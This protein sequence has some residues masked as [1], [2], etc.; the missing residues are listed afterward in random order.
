MT[1]TIGVYFLLDETGSMAGQKAEVV[2]GFN[3][4]LRECSEDEAHRYLLTFVKFSSG[5]Y[6]RV[7]NRTPLAHVAPLTDETYDPAGG[8]P[9]YDALG[10]LLTDARPEEG[11]GKLCIV[12]TDGEENSS[13]KWSREAINQLIKSKE[14][15]GFTFQYLGVAAE[16]WANERMFAGTVSAA[17]VL[18]TNSARGTRAVFAAMGGQTVSYA[19]DWAAGATGA[20]VLPNIQQE[21]TEE[22]AAGGTDSQ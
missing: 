10:T 5:H 8:T 1:T 2:S 15:D 17:N 14:G 9:L 19:Q 7:F 13:S 6:T 16:A 4:W 21:L 22:E 12:L 11:E 3:R 20:Q 18:R